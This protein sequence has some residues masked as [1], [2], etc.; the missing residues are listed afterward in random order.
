MVGN[1]SAQKSDDM[2]RYPDRLQQILNRLYKAYEHL[3]FEDRHAQIVRD[4]KQMDVTEDDRREL[5]RRLG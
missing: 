5:L 4:I 1:E 3:N 2:S